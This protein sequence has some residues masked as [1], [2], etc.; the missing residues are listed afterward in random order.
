MHSSD[1]RE[2]YSYTFDQ[3]KSYILSLNLLTFSED[4]ECAASVSRALEFQTII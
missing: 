1:Q 4:A 3:F 2:E